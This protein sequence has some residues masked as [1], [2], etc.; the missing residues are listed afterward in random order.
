MFFCGVTTRFKCAMQPDIK[1]VTRTKESRLAWLLIGLL[2]L[3]KLW[4]V[5]DQTLWARVDFMHDDLLFIRLADNLLQFGWLGPYNNLTLAKGPFYPMWIAF[6]FVIGVPLLLSQH[7]LYVAA[8]LVTY[9]ALGP[10]IRKLALRVAL[11]ALLLFNPVT[12]AFQMTCVLRDAL[13]PSLSLLAAGSAIGLFARYY[14][15]SRSL[16]GWAVMCGVATTAFWL[17]REE[18]VWMLPFVV[19]LGV[20]IVAMVAFR[21]LRNWRK[22][23]IITLPLLL[24]ILAVQAVSLVNRSQYGV[25]AIVE[26]NTPEFKSAYGAL[27]RVRP[28]EYKSQV[29]VPKEARQRIYAQSEAFAEL[30]PFFESAGFWTLQ[31][32]GFENHPS[33]ADEI[34]GG[35]FMWALRDAV[36]AAGYFSSGAQAAAFFQRLANEIN[37]ACETKRLDCLDERATMMPPWR[38]EYLFPITTQIVRSF[39]ILARFIWLSPD[40]DSVASEGSPANILLFEDL[41]REKLSAPPASNRGNVYVKGWAVHASEPLTASL[42]EAKTQDTVAVARFNPS[43]DIYQHFLSMNQNVMDASHARFEVKGNCIDPC[44]LRISGEQGLLANIPLKQGS[45]AWSAHP[46]W[47]YFDQVS[48]DL[49]PRQFQINALKLSLL[50]RIISVYH[51]VAPFLTLIAL[52]LMGIWLTRSFRNRKPTPLG[53][54]AVCIM[55]ALCTRLLILAIIEVTSFP[56][57]GVVYMSPLYPLLLLCSSLSIV[58]FLQNSS[59]RWIP[60][61]AA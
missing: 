10:L 11:F 52:V 61:R 60:D 33:G 18:G 45:T 41:T 55:M 46:L 51:V 25:Y 42:I 9:S 7:L 27:T 53:F 37:A 23:A 6:S 48:T 2:V 12:F 59:S 32:M 24:P 4:L 39:T 58:D 15:P 38:N 17:T 34:G 36:A 14:Y 50:K 57:I 20:S 44:V 19:P 5:S 1:T 8:S 28:V 40:S 35:W 31:S 22:L 29:P 26:F 54:I 56:A 43:P 21:E 47:V 30:Q 13:Y 49:T 16:I 3:F